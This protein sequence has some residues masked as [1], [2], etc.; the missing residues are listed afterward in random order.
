M[1]MAF[2]ALQAIS[3][4]HKSMQMPYSVDAQLNLTEE[5]G[6]PMP[7]KKHLQEADL[8]TRQ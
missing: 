6:C 3:L 4:R 7:H 1:R 8:H 2:A 5:Q